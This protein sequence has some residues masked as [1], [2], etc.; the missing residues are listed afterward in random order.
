MSEWGRA[1]T[2]M[3][4]SPESPTWAEV[5]ASD[6]YLNDLAALRPD[7]CTIQFVRLFS[8]NSAT[9]LCERSSFSDLRRA[10]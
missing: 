10:R 2:T 7:I 1:N 4:K 3:G 8:G 9:P 5:I 6:R